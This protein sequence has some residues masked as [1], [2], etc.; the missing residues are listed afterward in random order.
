MKARF[1]RKL[2]ANCCSPLLHTQTNLFLLKYMQQIKAFKKIKH[3]SRVKNN[4]HINYRTNNE[5]C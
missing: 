1:R 5:K 3:R 2:F 4:R